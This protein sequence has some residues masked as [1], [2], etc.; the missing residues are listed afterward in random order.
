MRECMNHAFLHQDAL[1]IVLTVILGPEG[2]IT[3]RPRR[4]QSSSTMADN[5]KQLIYGIRSVM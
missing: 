3:L 4:R 2:A 1:G 5:S